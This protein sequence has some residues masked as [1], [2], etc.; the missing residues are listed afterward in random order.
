M[1][2]FEGAELVPTRGVYDS[3]IHSFGLAG[4]AAAA[5]FYF[6]EMR[7]KGIEPAAS[8]YK[9]LFE[10]FARCAAAS[11]TSNLCVLIDVCLY[12]DHHIRYLS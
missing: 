4:D 7:E 1:C 2:L 6:W 8:T 11:I 9:C 3:I 5:E 10:A 12:S